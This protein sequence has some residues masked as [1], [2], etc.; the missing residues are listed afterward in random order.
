MF[1]CAIPA[2]AQTIRA[3]IFFLFLSQPLLSL[4]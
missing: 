2:H 4:D 1:A 3:G